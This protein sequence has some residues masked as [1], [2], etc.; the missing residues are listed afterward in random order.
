MYLD[1]S[2]AVS[3][4]SLTNLETTKPQGPQDVSPWKEAAGIAS[5]IENPIHS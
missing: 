2:L 4:L 5:P 3:A 1:K